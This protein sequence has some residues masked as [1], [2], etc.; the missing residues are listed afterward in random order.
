MKKFKRFLGDALF[1][2]YAFLA[3]FIGAIVVIC[4]YIFDGIKSLWN[5]IKNTFK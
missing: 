2:I 4:E 3:F 5:A 1:M